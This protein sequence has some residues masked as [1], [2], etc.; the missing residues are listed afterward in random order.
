MLGVG[1]RADDCAL[2][3]AL[4]DARTI[5]EE[6][7]FS[8]IVVIINCLDVVSTMLYFSGGLYSHRSAPL[9]KHRVAMLYSKFAF[10]EMLDVD[11]SLEIVFVVMKMNLRMRW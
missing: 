10:D 4:A 2:C 1:G 6:V 11:I 8:Y 9:K 3:W 7:S 5:A